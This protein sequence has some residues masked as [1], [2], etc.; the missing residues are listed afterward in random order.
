MNSPRPIADSFGQGNVVGNDRLALSYRQCRQLAQQTARNFY[1]SFMVL[2]RPKR[3]AMCA[4]YAFMR[5]TDDI[6]DS[7]APIEQ[8]RQALRDWRCQLEEALAGRMP[9]DLWWMAL[10]DT[11]RQYAIPVERLHE[12]IDGVTSDLDTCRYAT[13]QDLYG[14]CYRVAS[15]VGLA[16]LPIWGASDPRA[17]QPAVAC[18]IA[19]QLTN[20]LRDLV[21]DYGRNRI[22][23]PQEDLD[24]FG[25]TEGM[26][27]ARRP[28]P[29]LENLV[30][31]EIDRA[32]GY[33]RTSLELATYLPPTGR[34]ILSV[35]YG[36]YGGLLEAIA[37]RPMGILERRLSLPTSQKIGCVLQALPIRYLG[38]S[39]PIPAVARP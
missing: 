8:R 16:C 5:G 39:M 13:F 30:A 10:V 28:T 20:V 17:A 34:A 31:F 11:I 21:E 3:S 18:G 32:R 1:Y 25:V 27:A 19:F 37:K 4:L 15:A 33:Y 23:L 35:M 14:Y 12:V 26:I 29:Q 38:R 2:P 6:G 36:V 24:R 7:V 9:P 22:Y